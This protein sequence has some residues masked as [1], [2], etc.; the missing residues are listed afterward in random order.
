MLPLQIIHIIDQ[1]LVRPI[2]IGYF[3]I[4]ILIFICWHSCPFIRTAGNFHKLNPVRDW[5]SIITGWLT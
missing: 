3:K 1:T 4:N 5:L 2:P